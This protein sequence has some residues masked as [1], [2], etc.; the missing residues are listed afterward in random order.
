MKTFILLCITSLIGTGAF[1][2][3]LK[4][5]NSLPGYVIGFGVWILFFVWFTKKSNRS[6]RR[7]QQE[8]LFSE[9]L[10]SHYKN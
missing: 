6:A 9:W 7:R 3:A 5:P 1:L 2:S 4:M 8:R 10:R